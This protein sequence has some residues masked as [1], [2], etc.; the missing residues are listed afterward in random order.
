MWWTV[1]GLVI[2][3]IVAVIGAIIGTKN[4]LLR[5]SLIA[6]AAV[7]LVVGCVSAYQDNQSAVSNQQLLSSANQKLVDQGKLITFVDQTVGDLGTL[8]RLTAGE[9]YYVR[10]AVGPKS[11]MDDYLAGIEQKFKGA[12]SSGLLAVR[13][14]RPDC[15]P[16]DQ[17]ASC[18]VLVFGSNLTP[19]AAEV[20]ERFA[21]ENGFP[22]PDEHAYMEPEPGQP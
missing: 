14:R 10:I 12:G 4:S 18:Y 20:F 9:K 1:I 17:H 8:N 5:F 13:P 3:S 22:P 6:L 15:N 19:A 11:V 7:G 21:N 16:E 2:T